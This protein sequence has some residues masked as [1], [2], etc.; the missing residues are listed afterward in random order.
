MSYLALRHEQDN[1]S[2]LMTKVFFDLDTNVILT[3]KQRKGH[4]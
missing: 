2:P 4:I 1:H 3:G